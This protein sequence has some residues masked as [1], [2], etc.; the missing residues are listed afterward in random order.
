[1]LALQQAGSVQGHGCGA[2]GRYVFPGRRHALQQANDAIIVL[3]M[4]RARH[5]ARQHDHVVVMLQGSI[6][7]HVRHQHRA[8]A[9]AYRAIRQSGRDDFDTGAA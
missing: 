8:A 4:L 6:Q 3:Q 1:M 9:G 5:A 7:R 2:D